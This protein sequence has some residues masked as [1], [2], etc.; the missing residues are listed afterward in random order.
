MNDGFR[1]PF[2]LAR[3]DHRKTHHGG[4]DATFALTEVGG[5]EARMQA[6]HRYVSPG[7][8][9]RKFARGQ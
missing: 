1:A 9:V 5:D 3:K 7:E 8:E 4:E 6:V 2:R